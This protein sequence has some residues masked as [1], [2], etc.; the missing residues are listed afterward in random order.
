MEE[1]KLKIGL[2]IDTFFPMADGV[3]MVVDNYARRLSEKHDVTVFAPKPRD[4][5]YK[6]DLP[7]KI[8]RCN[9]MRLVGLDYD[10]PMPS[11]DGKF[12]KEIEKGDFD[13]IHIHSPFG[14]GK[15]GAI[16][17]RKHKIPC[18]ATL[19]S[20]FK[21][22]FLK[23]TKSNAIA[24]AMIKEVAKTFNLCGQLW[25][26]N[27]KCV[28]LAREYGYK[29]KIKIVP[30]GCDMKEGSNDIEQTKEIREKYSP[31]GEKILL[32]VGRINSL[33]NIEFQLK[34]AKELN[35][36]DFKFNFLFVG[37]GD[38]LEKF[39]KMAKKMELDNVYFLGKTNS[40]QEMASYYA[41]ADLFVF[42]S[43]YDTDG[44]VKIEAAA[45][46]V[47][48]IMLDDTFA[49]SAVTPDVN[50]YVSVLEEEVFADKIINIFADSENYEKVKEKAKEDLYV[51]WEDVLVT[52]EKN[53]YDL[54]RRNKKKYKKWY[55][56]VSTFKR[57]KVEKKEAKKELKKER[58]NN[59]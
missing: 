35:K 44:I 8:V 36:K 46:K 32:F 54:V 50:G 58:K 42:P 55:D 20:Q 25:T 2:F 19:H 11:F 15:A 7:Y 57:N 33:K 17:A 52:V 59:K 39:T 48:S 49:A 28:Q 27:P 9:R 51:T 22:D 23:A 12:K 16:Y 56:F 21:Y 24:N 4:K 29:H 47:P 34:V 5:K 53:Y 13:I 18:V 26:M 45:Y 31:N 6:D 38:E 30:N 1:K 10:L 37:G 43:A 14:V 3:I 40:R 41:A